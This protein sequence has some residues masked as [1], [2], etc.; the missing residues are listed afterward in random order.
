MNVEDIKTHFLTNVAKEK[1]YYYITECVLVA[2]VIQYIKRK[3]RSI[4]PVITSLVIVY[5]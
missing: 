5:F 4:L 1:E 2:L 3:N